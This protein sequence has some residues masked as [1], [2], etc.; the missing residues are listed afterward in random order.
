MKSPEELGLSAKVMEQG[1]KSLTS[2][3]SGRIGGLVTRRK[4]EMKEA[5]RFDKPEEGM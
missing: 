1:W 2:K 4:R 3:E 5:A